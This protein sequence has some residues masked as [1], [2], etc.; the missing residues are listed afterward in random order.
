VLG[1]SVVLLVVAVFI[2]L[3]ALTQNSSI[4]AGGL[5]PYVGKAPAASF[6]AGQPVD[7]MQ[8]GAMEGQ[9][10]HIHQH[11][12]VFIN[13]QQ[14]VIPPVIGNI[15]DSK[16]KFKCF[17]W[18][19]THDSSGVIHLEAPQQYP[20]TFGAFLDSWAATPSKTA[21][22]AD[23]AVLN[24]IL[25]RNPDVVAL[26]GKAYGGDIRKIPLGA[27]TMISLSYGSTSVTQQPYDFSQVDR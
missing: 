18:I 27:H 17:Y 14:Q 23:H 11:V 20:A 25:T 8:C 24:T 3:H 9:V 13:G 6:V 4:S 7:G 2:V 1:G 10:V 26:N 22:G 12:D 19:H 16:N 21:P 5:H 15:Y